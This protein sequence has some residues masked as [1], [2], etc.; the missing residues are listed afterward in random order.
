MGLTCDGEPRWL[1]I[2]PPRSGSFQDSVHRLAKDSGI[3][4]WS[5]FQRFLCLGWLTG[6]FSLGSP[7][8]LHSLALPPVALRTPLSLFFLSSAPSIP[9]SPLRVLHPFMGRVLGPN[10]PAVASTK[11]TFPWIQ[12]GTESREQQ[13]RSDWFCFEELNR[14]RTNG[15]L[16]KR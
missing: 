5:V 3:S 10:L 15:M 12:G 14:R 1:L 7:L 8:S 13:V 6:H 2:G 16:M 9:S 4:V 11:Q